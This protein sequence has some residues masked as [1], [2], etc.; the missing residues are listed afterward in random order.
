MAETPLWRLGEPRRCES[1]DRRVEPDR[2]S[3]TRPALKPVLTGVLGG[4][5][6]HREST[7]TEM[8]MLIELNSDNR[9][10]LRTLFDRYPYVH[11]SVAAVIEGGMGRVFADAQEEPSAL[12][13]P[14]TA[15]A[16]HANGAAIA[17]GIL[18]GA[19]AGPAIA[20]S[21]PPSITRRRRR[22][23]HPMRHRFIPP[24]RRRSILTRRRLLLIMLRCRITRQGFTTAVTE[25]RP[26]P[27]VAVQRFALRQLD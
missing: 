22:I 20:S 14:G 11:G 24:C 27:S 5:S 19:L 16:K 1:N 15:Y 13:S 18:G 25:E 17:L 12:T 10:S 26:I 6:N 4:R 21:S 7:S 9:T 3:R 23:T 2:H 8:T